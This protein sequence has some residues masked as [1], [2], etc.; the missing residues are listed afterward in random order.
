MELEIWSFV[1]ATCW[2]SNV[3]SSVS[4][5]WISVV[6]S[7]PSCD[8]PGFVGAGWVDA[9]VDDQTATELEDAILTRARQ[10]RIS[11]LAQ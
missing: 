11:G 10:L 7:G 4:C 9:V 6:S 8:L 3:V 1:R 5:L 2:R